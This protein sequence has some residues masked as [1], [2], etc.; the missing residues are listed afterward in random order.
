M[1]Q[2]IAALIERLRAKGTPIFEGMLNAADALERLTQP[3]DV[4]PVRWM[5]DGLTYPV[6]QTDF[7][8]VP[9][10]PQ[11]ALYSAE[12]VARLQ[13]E[14]DSNKKQADHFFTENNALNTKCVNLEGERDAFQKDNAMLVRMHRD[15][16][17]AAMK[18]IDEAGSAALDI[19]T[20]QEQV[21]M[22][23][24]AAKEAM[25]ELELMLIDNSG[26]NCESDY[27]RCHDAVRVILYPALA[28]TETKGDL[29]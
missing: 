5:L 24:D 16:V 11:H 9:H 18:A 12:V 2:D 21:K 4:E 1:T 17:D 8:G 28:A 13:Q 7:N 3:V 26:R 25:R 20:R 6:Q 23:Q 10:E 15:A 29:K 14:R 22:L 27:A 19:E